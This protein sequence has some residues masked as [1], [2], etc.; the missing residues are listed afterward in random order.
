V[1]SHRFGLWLGGARPRTLSA[2]VAPVA[3]G[4]GTAVGADTAVQ[5]YRGLLASTVA[6]ALQI[7]VN[8]ANDYSDGVR[9]TADARRVGPERLV[10]SGLVEPARVRAAAGVCSVPPFPFAPPSY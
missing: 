8:Y 9:G 3:V 5:W 6:I 4:A 10:G 1:A 2:A 7:G